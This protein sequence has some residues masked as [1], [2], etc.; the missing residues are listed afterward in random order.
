MLVL[1]LICMGQSLSAV[2]VE[3]RQYHGTQIQCV[4]GGA[5]ISETQLGVYSRA[6]IYEQVF[7]GTVQS[8]VEISF[9]DKRLKI[10]PDEI[11]LGDVA[12]EITATVNQAC[13]PENL[14]EIKAGDK[15][16]FYFKT[17]RYLHPDA[18]PPYIT[19][20][21]LMVVFDSPSK[22]V[23]NAEYDICLLRHHSD[24]RES[25]IA[26]MPPRHE[27]TC[28]FLEQPLQLTS[29]FPQA[30]L[31]PQLPTTMFRSEG[32]NL[33]DIIAPGISSTQSQDDECHR[34]VAHPASRR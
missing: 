7:T 19:S 24:L 13:L 17:K 21:G 30:A 3:G 28:T 6:R 15:W 31:F 16:L 14:P 33:T 2:I 22:P 20:D 10:I 18:T 27:H 12:G 25:C 11:F 1:A 8:V 26:A 5:W 4:H 9:T 23:S 34:S 32:F 29:P